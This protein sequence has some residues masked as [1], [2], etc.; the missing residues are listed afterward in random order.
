MMKYMHFKSKLE[1]KV[2]RNYL[3]IAMISFIVIVFHAGNKS[4]WLDDL[5]TILFVERNVGI[6]ENIRRILSDA[7]SNT[8]GFYLIAYI[9]FRIAPYGT[10]WL[11]LPSIVFATIGIYMCGKIAEKLKGARAG[12]M[13]AL[14][15]GTSLFL[16]KEGANTFR[17][18]GLLFLLSTLLIWFYL[19]RMDHAKSERRIDIVLYGLVMTGLIYTHYFGGIIVFAF[20][21][22]DA[23]LL[24]QKRISLKI[25][26]SYIMAA[27]LF[28]PFLLYAYGKA[29]GYANSEMAVP[30]DLRSL[31]RLVLAIFSGSLILLLCFLFAAVALAAPKAF[32]V[33]TEDLSSDQKYICALIMGVCIF[34]VG[35][36]YICCRYLGVDSKILWSRYYI[37]ILPM[38]LIVS[39][40]G[41]DMVLKSLN[42][43]SFM[44]VFAMLA[45]LFG[46]QT[47]LEL[48]EWS[49]QK[50]APWEQAL[51]WI[52][53]QQEAHAPDSSILGNDELMPY[54]LTHGG[55]REALNVITVWHLENMA[56][57]TQW[58]RL[59]CFDPSETTIQMLEES[60]DLIDAKAEY[61]VLVYQRKA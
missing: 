36:A 34:T 10:L 59:Y 21:I 32:K 61:K 41:L 29:I 4:L 12:M 17:S 60:Y 27:L 20:A 38:A 30:P 11:K 50:S 16:I 37:S 52:Y 42:Q 3:M 47:M 43:K 25:V 24:W 56:D 31:G 48:N 49:Q 33:A 13:A 6:S 8:P 14:L 19:K 35:M 26:Q 54:Y 40:I 44:I 1:T 28:L 18:Y 57:D 51:D 53:D 45:L 55:K 2:N 58:L 15:A 46:M 9:W 23:L 7:H 5:L 22:G 39:A